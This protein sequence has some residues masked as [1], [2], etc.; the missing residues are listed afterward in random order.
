MYSFTENLPPTPSTLELSSMIWLYLC[1]LISFLFRHKTDLKFLW[2]QNFTE[3][4][5]CRGI[6]KYNL[7]KK[8]TFSWFVLQCSFITPKTAGCLFIQKSTWQCA[9]L[10]YTIYFLIGDSSG[11]IH[12][13]RPLA[14][15]KWFCFCFYPH[16]SRSADQTS[17]FSQ[18]AYRVHCGLWLA[19]LIA[20][21]IYISLNLDIK[22]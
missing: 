18:R 14:E 22:C 7:W 12:S 19:I 8:V 10:V 15:W 4:K 5:L 20:W 3:W 1:N 13:S 17:S 2:G 21:Y 9:S 11:T 16:N 6:R